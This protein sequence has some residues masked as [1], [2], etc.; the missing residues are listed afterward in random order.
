MML[1]LKKL[2]HGLIITVMSE[3]CHIVPSDTLEFLPEGCRSCPLARFTLEQMMA[4]GENPASVLADIQANCTGWLDDQEP[5]E[6]VLGTET[7][8]DILDAMAIAIDDNCPYEAAVIKG[9]R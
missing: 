1:L 3:L 6:S 5:M 9:S 7:D 2:K 4:G 8:G